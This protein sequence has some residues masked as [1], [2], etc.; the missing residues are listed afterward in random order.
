VL[1]RAR[2]ECLA[3][4][5]NL[6]TKKGIPKSQRD[7]AL[8]RCRGGFP[9][10]IHLAC[11][12]KGRLLSVVLSSVRVSA[13]AA[14]PSL[15]NCVTQC[16]CHVLSTHPVD[17]ANALP[18]YSPT[19][20]TASKVVGECCAGVASPTPFPSARITKSVAPG[21]RD[22]DPV[23]TERLTGDAMWLRDVNRLKQWPAIATRYAKRAVNYRAMVVIASLMM[24]LPS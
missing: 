18:I 22:A 14:A 4:E 8:G 12:G 10:K 9:P 1:T 19:G 20:A 24:W 7:W 15:R 16:G 3:G 17:R 11:D 2:R 13:I 5:P 23:L 6:S 21:V